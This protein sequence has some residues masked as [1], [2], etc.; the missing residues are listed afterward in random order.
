M[1]TINTSAALWL[2]VKIKLIGVAWTLVIGAVVIAG[3]WI[4]ARWINRS[5]F[6]DRR[7]RDARKRQGK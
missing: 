4:F 3:V 6:K 1:N 5:D 2:Y 7:K